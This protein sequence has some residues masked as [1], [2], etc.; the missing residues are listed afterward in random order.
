[1]IPQVA[2]MKRGRLSPGGTRCSTLAPQ[3]LQ[4]FI[5][6]EIYAVERALYKDDSIMPLTGLSVARP[7]VRIAHGPARRRIQLQEEIGMKVIGLAAIALA[8]IFAETAVAD[9]GALHGSWKGP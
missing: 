7:A 8:I 1:M 3:A 5:R 2:Q 9:T 4:N 6:L